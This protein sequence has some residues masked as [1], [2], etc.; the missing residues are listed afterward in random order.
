M[1]PPRKPLASGTA[2]SVTAT[3]QP[4]SS[5]CSR[6]GGTSGWSRPGVIAPERVTR[7]IATEVLS[8]KSAF[9]VDP[10]RCCEP[11]FD[12]DQYLVSLLDYEQQYA[13]TPTE[14]EILG[15][16]VRH[17][18]ALCRAGRYVGGW[19]CPR[20]AM[21]YLDV[22]VAVR[23]RSRALSLAHR[24]RQQSVYHPWSGDTLW[25]SKFVARQIGVQLNVG[26]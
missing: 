22:T 24:N 11:E 23:G 4:G 1:W 16:I 5:K 12:S 8:V 13:D 17:L 25:L 15:W 21:F 2:V 20:D 19:W 26:C 14:H 6:G 3:S 7:F 18:P 9:T 10:H